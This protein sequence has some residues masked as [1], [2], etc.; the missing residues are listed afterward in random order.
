MIDLIYRWAL[1]MH[2][3]INITARDP[4]LSVTYICIRIHNVNGARSIS[5]LHW[6]ACYMK[7]ITG[8]A[9]TLSIFRILLFSKRIIEVSSGHYIKIESVSPSEQHCKDSTDIGRCGDNY[10]IP[11]RREESQSLL[12]NTNIT[13]VAIIGLIELLTYY[14]P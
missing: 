10:E 11:T 12:W 5:N 2:A 6:N 8:M 7:P 1:Y 13:L 9:W 4:I 14:F 3:I